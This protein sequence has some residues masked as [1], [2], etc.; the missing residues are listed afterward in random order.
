MAQ[1]KRLSDDMRIQ[2]TFIFIGV[3]LTLFCAFATFDGWSRLV[4]AVDTGDGT[5]IVLDLAEG[6]EAD[7]SDI[8]TAVDVL[9]ERLENAGLDA[10]VRT[11]GDQQIYIEAS[12]ADD[13]ESLV[14]ELAQTGHVEFVRSDAIGD[15][16]A[17][18][19]L[20]NSS[21]DVELGEGTYTAFITADEVES[22]E[23]Y[24][25]YGYYFI[26]TFQL[27]DEGTETYA[28]VSAELAEDSGSVAIVIDGTVLT[29][30]TV[31]SEVTDGSIMVTFSSETDAYG[32][33]SLLTSEEMPIH[34]SVS[35][36]YELQSS[37]DIDELVQ[38]LIVASA[39]IG[40]LLI[41]LAIQ[42]RAGVLLVA[43][44]GIFTA[45]MTA[46]V[47]SLL[48]GRSVLVVDEA[49]LISVATSML[50][51]MFCVIGLL[52]SL[53]AE[54]KS[55][56][57]LSD[58]C[59]RAG[60]RAGKVIINQAVIMAVVGFACAYSG[61]W[62]SN[63]GKVIVIVAACEVVV[64][65]LFALPLF[66]L[67][68]DGAAERRPALWGVNIKPKVAQDTAGTHTRATTLA[69]NKPALV[70]TALLVI[71]SLAGWVVRGNPLDVNLV[72]GSQIIM[73]DAGS[74]S[75]ED[76]RQA[77]DE[78]G[79]SFVE[80]EE[81]AA[82]DVYGYV[83]GLNTTD[84]EE[85]QSISED[86]AESLEL[87]VSSWSI[88]SV[89]RNIADSELAALA[90]VIVLSC[91]ISFIWL[92]VRTKPAEAALAFA[93]IVAC[94]LTAIGDLAWA[95]I[96]LSRMGIAACIAV[97]LLATL[98]EQFIFADTKA[99]LLS[100]ASLDQSPE[101][102]EAQT[103]KRMKGT[104]LSVNT[105]LIWCVLFVGCPSIAIL[106]LGS[107]FE[108]IAVYAVAMCAVA[109]VGECIV[110]LFSSTKRDE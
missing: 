105:T 38:S 49:S 3:V 71:A 88:A 102:T 84:I 37:L 30:P 87:D 96:P 58:A 4:S 91:A 65:M 108:W 62:L 55:G 106:Y 76:L 35:S 16:D 40:A 82:D 45:C 79:A 28:E 9:R 15:A 8:A 21:S 54:L 20:E 22:V 25:Y 97:L 94:A 68:C 64:C 10:E 67:I 17:L 95:E 99:L 44:S 73:S 85:A 109:F 103:Q 41:V 36:S 107:S 51:G 47:V 24:S 26:V 100:G 50:C 11:M 2:A 7:A 23:V 33:S 74:A 5:A 12:G 52:A 42:F 69:I 59:E 89:G 77:F 75:Q 80:I 83:V 13:V 14:S 66:R 72:S 98:L 63:F 90:A 92:A 53:R 39:V 27:N 101:S 48:A 81:I 70:C 86:V 32:L 110:P 78:A 56:R 29:M 46:G 57:R 93:G 19:L 6:V 31:S 18:E 34:M 1:G 60:K 43:L 61:T 104:S